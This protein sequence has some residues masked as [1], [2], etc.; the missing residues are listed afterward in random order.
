[1][2]KIILFVAFF[3][4]LPVFCLAANSSSNGYNWGLIIGSIIVGGIFSL[5]ISIEKN[6][7]QNTKENIWYKEI[8]MPRTAK[9]IKTVIAA[10]GFYFLYI[11]IAI[12]LLP[13]QRD[14]SRILL[15]ALTTFLTIFIHIKFFNKNEQ[16][17]KT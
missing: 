8:R 12:L 4:F 6:K 13:D 1:M 10:L 3:V 11:F 15:A 2:K 7:N 16:R 5:A 17:N 9:F 14:W